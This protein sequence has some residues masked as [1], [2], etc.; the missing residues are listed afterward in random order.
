MERV[1]VDSN[2]MI[3]WFIPED[4][5]E[6]ALALCSD[7]LM[8]SI[9]IVAPM[10]SLLEFSNALRKYYV[11]GIIGVNEVFKIM[12]LLYEMKIEFMDIDEG[13]LRE[14]LKYSLEN[15]IVVYDAYY[16]ILAYKLDTVLYTADEKLL[17][18]LRDK[19]SRLKHIRTYRGQYTGSSM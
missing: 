7:Y 15:H 9:D 1:V 16:I 12:K 8:G 10:Y 14:A 17:R 5:S 18:R 19:E 3:K 11:R 2:V 4:Y 6:Q 13:L